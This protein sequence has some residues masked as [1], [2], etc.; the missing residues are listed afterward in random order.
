MSITIICELR[1]LPE[2]ADAIIQQVIEQFSLPASS[3]AGRRFAR[4]SQ[5]VDDPAWLLYLGEWESR[6]RFEAY[7]ATAPL[8]GSLDQHRSAPACRVFRRLALFERVL[9][10]VGLAYADIVTGPPETGA[11]RRDLALAYHRASLRSQAG[12]VLHSIY[13]GVDDP[14][15]LAIVSGFQAPAPLVRQGFAPNRALIE[16]LRATGATVEQFVGRA[17]AETTGS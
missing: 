16:Q 7:R 1:P 9:A 13:E 11:T 15:S 12:L 2:H 10:P 4:L 14:A 8:P 6:E 5:H 17:L 3:V